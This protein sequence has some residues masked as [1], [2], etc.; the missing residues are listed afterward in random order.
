MVKSKAT[1]KS[2]FNCKDES[3]LMEEAARTA[4]TTQKVC[5][6]VAVDGRSSTAFTASIRP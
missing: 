4:R 1:L 5:K 6:G 3:G 2:Q